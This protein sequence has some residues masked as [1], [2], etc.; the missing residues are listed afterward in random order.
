MRGSGRGNKA[1]AVISG[2]RPDCPRCGGFLKSNGSNRWLCTSCNFN[3]TK[4]MRNTMLAT[5]MSWGFDTETAERHARRCERPVRLLVTSAQHNTKVHAGFLR[6]LKAAA[7][8]YKCHIAMVPVHY[9]NVS[10]MH[11]DPKEWVDDVKPYLVKSDIRFGNAVIKSDVR[12]NATTLH[13]LAGKQAHGGKHWM[14]FGHPQVAC[15]P[16]ASPGGMLP[17]KLFTTGS[18]TVQN[19]TQSD[20]GM[21]A[22]FHHVIGALILERTRD[23]FVFVRQ[24]NASSDGSFYDLDRKFHADGRVTK[25]HRI[26]ALV[27]GDEHVKFNILERETYGKGGIV[28]TLKPRYIVRH[29]VLDGYAGSHHHERD[30]V[31]QYVKH[32]K[33]DNSYRREL[34]QC[35]EFINRTTPKFATSLI[36]PSNHHDHLTKWL[37]RTSVNHDHENAIL[38]AELQASMRK[39]ALRGDNTDPLYLYAKSRLKCQYKF[40]DRNK[41]YMIGDVDQSQHSDIGINGSKG[42]ARQLAG[43]TLKMNVG[44]SHAA[45]IC[46]GVYQSGTSTGTREYERGLSNHS[47]THIVQY[48]NNKRTLLDAYKGRWRL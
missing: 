16:V 41:P 33:G 13:P 46:M 35:V 32:H 22:E 37:N 44:H 18:C 47:N 23:G 26:A 30:P 42:S 25:G 20:I 17:K 28:Q 38:L 45:R 14:I 3:P 40:L 6:A 24:L 4:S 15:E 9:R 36:V 19:Y 34:D 31:L 2:K 39:A 12:V 11:N 27:T 1:V 7:K 8:H 21:K 43:T 29:D 48:G 10:L 5:D